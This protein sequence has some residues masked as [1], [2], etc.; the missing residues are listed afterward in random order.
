[1]KSAVREQKK[2]RVRIAPSPT[3]PLHIGTVRTALFNFLFA[4][5]HGGVFILR[6]EDT[7][8]ERSE[9]R[10]EKEIIEG[11]SWLGILWDEGPYRQSERAD[12]Y[13]V[14]LKKLIDEGLAYYCYCTKEE[15]SAEREAFI[16]QGLPPVYG[17][18]CRREGENGTAAKA[19]GYSVQGAK[20]RGEI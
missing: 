3:G 16:A 20:W 13:E 2:V 5:H 11:L 17:G 7:D 9:A 4:R 15:L 14:Y 19:T 8:A 18:R 10:Y 1:M 12:R 6:I